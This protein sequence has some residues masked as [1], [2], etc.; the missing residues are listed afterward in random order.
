[1]LSKEVCRRCTIAAFR[2]THDEIGE[3]ILENPEDWWTHFDAT[4]FDEKH[5]VYCMAANRFI[6]T[7]QSPPPKCHYQLEHLLQNQRFEES[8][9]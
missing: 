8:S 4:R 1:M 6:S 3:A 2:G 7:E 9:C 5:L